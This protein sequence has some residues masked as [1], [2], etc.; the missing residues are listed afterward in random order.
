MENSSLSILPSLSM[1]ARCLEEE[2][3]ERTEMQC[4]MF[5]AKCAFRVFSSLYWDNSWDKA[6]V[7]LNSSSIIHKTKTHKQSVLITLPP[8]THTVY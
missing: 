1:S 4:D 2:G 3:R 5:K 6:L 8:F 7:G